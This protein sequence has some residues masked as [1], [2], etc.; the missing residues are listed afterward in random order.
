MVVKRFCKFEGKLWQIINVFISLINCCI[1]KSNSVSLHHTNVISL[2]SV[3][4][5][6]QCRYCT[7][8][9]INFAN[10]RTIYIHV[11]PI[12]VGVYKLSEFSLHIFHYHIEDNTG[13]INIGKPLANL[14]TFYLQ[15]YGIFNIHLPS[16]GHLY[17]TFLP[18]TA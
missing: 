14:Q 2:S 3:M 11:L 12:K 16:L 1:S 13:G 15:T 4:G 8:F 7:E 9:T 18:Q 6:I 10:Y 5:Y 17:I